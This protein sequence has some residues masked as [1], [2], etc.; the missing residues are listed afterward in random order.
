MYS[1]KLSPMILAEIVEELKAPRLQDEGEN[2]KGT[3][4]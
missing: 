4:E 1:I 2:A 3:L